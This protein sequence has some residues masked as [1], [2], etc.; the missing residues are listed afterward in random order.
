[1]KRDRE[2]S[3]FTII[4]STIASVPSIPYIPELRQY[5]GTVTSTILMG[6]LEIYFAKHPEGFCRF[7]E[8]QAG[9]QDYEPGNSWTEELAFSKD[10]FRT[11]FN[12][13]GV[14]HN[15]KT[16]Y[17]QAKAKGAEFFPGGYYCSYF[18]RR[19]G[20]TF[21]FRN[22]KKVNALFAVLTGQGGAA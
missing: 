16:Q 6:Q 15:S 19:S 22:D 10:E 5:T 20:L 9:H 4:K 14:R 21:Y 8:P 1:M 18:D 17:D 3:T 13:I 7:L 11:A 12:K 2:N